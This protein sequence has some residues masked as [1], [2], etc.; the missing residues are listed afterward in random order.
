MNTYC[1]KCK[2]D[3]VILTLKWLKQKII[4]YLCNQNIVFVVLKSQDL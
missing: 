2:K 3:A 4:D 1:L